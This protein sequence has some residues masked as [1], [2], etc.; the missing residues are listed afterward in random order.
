[1]SI[2]TGIS[3]ALCKGTKLGMYLNGIYDI[4]DSDSSKIQ[5]QMCRYIYCLKY[6]EKVCYVKLHVA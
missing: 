2:N 4:Y 1:M 6:V 5:F 3:Q